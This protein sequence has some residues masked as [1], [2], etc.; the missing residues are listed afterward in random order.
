MARNSGPGLRLPGPYGPSEETTTAVSSSEVSDSYHLDELRIAL[1]PSHPAHILPPE[2]E[3]GSSVLDLGCGA[4]QTMIAAY[5]NHVTFGLD[6]DLS[7]LQF[8]KTLS[9]GVKFCCGRAEELPYRDDAFDLVIARVSL[10]YTDI[11]RTLREAQRVL[12][13][14]GRLWITLHSWKIP[15]HMASQS[16]WRGKLFFLYIILNSL[17]FHW[18]QKQFSVCGRRESFQT[19]GGMLKVLAQCGFKNMEVTRG[20]HFLIEA[21]PAKV[22]VRKVQHATVGRR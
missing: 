13:P 5:P 20:R 4:G 7:V 17:S 12:K 14:D 19:E 16:N 3:R 8:G 6:I 1:D 10:A 22:A 11:E 21:Q 2:V 9:S 18:F 15:F